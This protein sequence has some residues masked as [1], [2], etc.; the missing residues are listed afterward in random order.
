MESRRGSFVAA[1]FV[2]LSS[3]AAFA[4][5]VYH[6]Q[7]D[8]SKFGRINQADVPL[9]PGGGGQNSCVPTAT[10]NSFTWLQN[11]NPFLGNMLTGADPTASASDLGNNHMGSTSDAGT[12]ANGWIDGK[13]SWIA[14][15]A[16][17]LVTVDGQSHLYS[18]TNADIEQVRPTWQFFFNALTMGCDVEIGILPNAGGIGHALTLTSFHWVDQNMDNI[19]QMTEN[20]TIDYI[21]PANPAMDMIS[22]VWQDAMGILQTN[23]GG[24]Y[25]I[26]LTAI[27]CPVPTPGTAA[28]VIVAGIAAYRRRR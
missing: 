28:L 10:M 16:P 18:G 7:L 9:N 11:T 25:N 24:G 2:L 27:E 4:A 3:G 14:A 8:T 5:N 22:S 1:V 12:G 21:D 15:K 20:A 17:G 13:S 19:I 23:Y 26:A 6:V